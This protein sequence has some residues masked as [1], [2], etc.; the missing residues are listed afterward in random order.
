DF[1]IKALA[2]ALQKVP[3]A[4][5]TWT[6]SAMLKHKHSDVGVAVAIK[7]GLI[8]PVVR[9]AEQKSLSAISN[10]MKDFAARAR[11]R[12]LAPHE[13]RGGCPAFPTLAVYGTRFFPALNTPPHATILSVGAGEARPVVRDG[14]IEA[15]QIMTVGLSTDHR[16]VDGALGAE[17]LAAFRGY[18]EN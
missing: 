14:K 11:A 16:A 7:G 4:N 2:L 17:L 5:V 10:E 12:K 1:V 8:T 15:A 18:I 3:E 6:E 9:K 13:Y